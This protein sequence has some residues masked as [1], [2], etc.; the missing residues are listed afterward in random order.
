MALPGGC[1]DV[2][3]GT[4]GPVPPPCRFDPDSVRFIPSDRGGD[5]PFNPASLTRWKG[6][7]VLPAPNLEPSLPWRPGVPAIKRAGPSGYRCARVSASVE[8]RVTVLRSPFQASSRCRAP[9]LATAPSGPKYPCDFDVFAAVLHASD[10]SRGPECP[11]GS[12]ASAPL[13]RSCLWG[14]VSSLAVTIEFR[15]RRRIG[16]VE[17]DQVKGSRSGGS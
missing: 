10:G 15:E 6:S 17:P 4:V 8:S 9:G 1:G 13:N 16:G 5:V 11:G 12:G 14:A 3:P 2:S 7:L